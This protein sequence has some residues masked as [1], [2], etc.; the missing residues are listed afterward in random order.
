MSLTVAE[1][2]ALFAKHKVASRV[3]FAGQ[4][5][6]QALRDAYAAMDLFAFSSHSETQGMVLLE[7]MATGC[8]VIAGNAFT[9][10]VAFAL[11]TGGTHVPLTTTL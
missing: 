5:T 8:P 2:E 11:V 6:G 9:V 3:H 7:A 4:L 10:K 1:V